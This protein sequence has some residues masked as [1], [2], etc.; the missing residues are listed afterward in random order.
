MF[1]D[2]IATIANCGTGGNDY[3]RPWERGQD[4]GSYVF[5][6]LHGT[7]INALSSSPENPWAA[8]QGPAGIWRDIHGSWLGFLSGHFGWVCSNSLSPSTT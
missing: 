3:L 2:G 1:A 6:G 7:C 5:F 4:S 8:A